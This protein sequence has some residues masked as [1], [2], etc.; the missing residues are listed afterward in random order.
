[1]CYLK[2][3]LTK[4]YFFSN[5]H[6]YVNFSERYYDIK[7]KFDFGILVFFRINDIDASM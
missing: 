3:K 6:R 4:S 2:L 7:L 5:K 1:M